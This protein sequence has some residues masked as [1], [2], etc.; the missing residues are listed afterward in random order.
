MEKL[1]SHWL[2]RIPLAVVFL[3]Q[4]LNK[5]PFDPAGGEGFGLTSLVWAVVVAGE[6]LAGLGL[7]VGG[8]LAMTRI[9]PWVGD[10]I[11]RLSGF[12]IGSI[13]AGVIWSFQPT[14]FIDVILYD[15]FH[16]LLWFGGLYLALRGNKA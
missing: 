16:V 3:Q 10:S 14:S 1:F 7:I 2:L 8:L 12:T 13:M 9:Y 11:T 6:L 4:G 15:N 5:L